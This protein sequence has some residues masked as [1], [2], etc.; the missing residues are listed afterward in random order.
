MTNKK[1]ENQ[2]YSDD[3][4]VFCP[5]CKGKDYNRFRCKNEMIKFDGKYVVVLGK[6]DIEYLEEDTLLCKKCEKEFK[7]KYHEL[8]SFLDK[9][10]KLPNKI[11]NILRHINIEAI[12]PIGNQEDNGVD[13]HN[14]ILVKE[15]FDIIKKEEQ[16][17]ENVE[18]EEEQVEEKV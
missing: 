8:V 1:I 16:V 18:E 5:T 13:L 6:N 3:I 2:I 4:L 12:Q 14:V 7:I 10:P 9:H 15:L 11:L 17:E